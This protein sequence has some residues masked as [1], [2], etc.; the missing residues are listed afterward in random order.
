MDGEHYC[1]AQSIVHFLSA[2]PEA[3]AL[4]IAGFHTGRPKVA[5]FFDI[6]VQA[7]LAIEAIW[8]RDADGGERGWERE[9]VD[10]D[11]NRWMVVVI[12]KRDEREG[13][14][15]ESEKEREERV[16]ASMLIQKNNRHP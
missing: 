3:R 6:A 16:F 10:M 12:L 11:K 4:V 7:G 1:L 5:A 9:R 8:E 14:K 15:E 2:K 13:I